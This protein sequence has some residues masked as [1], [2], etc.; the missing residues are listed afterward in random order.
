MDFY[1]RRR[2]K[3]IVL[4]CI[5][6]SKKGESEESIKRLL[7]QQTRSVSHAEVVACCAAVKG[8]K[9]VPKLV[10]VN[11]VPVKGT[12]LVP[13]LVSVVFPLKGLSWSLN[14][15]VLRSC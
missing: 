5:L 8:T 3:F 7:L 13:K 12:K 10:R 14:W 4:K 2:S 11:C 6:V 9:L 15:L 1:G